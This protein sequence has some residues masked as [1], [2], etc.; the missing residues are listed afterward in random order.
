MI[1]TLAL[2][3]NITSSCAIV[4]ANKLVFQLLDFRYPV[5]LTCVHTLTTLVAVQCFRS[6][7]ANDAAN[8]P[9]PVRAAVKLAGSF[10]GYI[11]ICNVSLAINSVGFYQLTKVA[12]A[13][14]VLL[15]DAMARRR[16]PSR[17]VVLCVT[18]VCAGIG[19]AT[20]YDSEIMANLAGVLVGTAAVMISAIYGLLIEHTSKHYGATSMQLMKQYLPYATL[21]LGC[22]VPM[23]RLALAN[24]QYA[25][26]TEIQVLEASTLIRLRALAIILSSAVLGALVTFSTFFVIR[27]TSSLTYAVSG[28]V[29]TIVILAAGVLLF[30]EDLS[31]YK[32]AGVFIAM[33]GLCAYA[34]AQQ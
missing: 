9:I 3:L 28:H 13:P 16:L 2:F 29:K 22:C 27:N 19:L 26:P 6:H 21:M 20:V 25:K 17:N 15:M 33:T 5:A 12:V 4:L 11:I 31:H 24:Y 14:A 30:N 23:E 8:E 7:F 10:T 1:S 18:A 34:L 32:V